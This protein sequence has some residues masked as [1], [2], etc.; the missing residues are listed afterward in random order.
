ME[1]AISLH[2]F[3]SHNCTKIFFLS[4][5]PSLPAPPSPPPSSPPATS[6][7]FHGGKT[8]PPCCFDDHVPYL[9]PTSEMFLSL[10]LVQRGGHHE[11]A[12]NKWQLGRLVGFKQTVWGPE[13][14]RISCQ[15]RGWPV[16]ALIGD[17]PILDSPPEPGLSSHPTPSLQE[18]DLGKRDRASFF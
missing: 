5:L 17:W 12:A 7:Q 14:L 3:V 8:P 1:N 2:V 15:P 10:S 4:F 16:A 11:E 6:F 13:A 18:K 9:T